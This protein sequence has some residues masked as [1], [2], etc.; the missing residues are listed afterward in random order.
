MLTVLAYGCASP[1]EFG[2]LATLLQECR[3]FSSATT[4]FRYLPEWR[5]FFQHGAI[6]VTL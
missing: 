1:P 2:P 5:F 3:D 4:S 6:V